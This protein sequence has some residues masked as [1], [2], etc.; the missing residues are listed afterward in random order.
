MLLDAV[1]ADPSSQPSP[2]VARPAQNIANG[3]TSIRGGG[4]LVQLLP[5]DDVLLLRVGKQEPDSG[6]ITRVPEDSANQL[7]KNTMN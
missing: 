6:Q 3:E 5:A 2:V 1:L 4:Q 7:K